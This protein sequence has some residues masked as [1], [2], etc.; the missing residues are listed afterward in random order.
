MDTVA[1]KDIVGYE[2]IYQ[3]S[4]TGQVK[5]L[6]AAK[7]RSVQGNYILAQVDNGSGHIRVGLC[8][9]SRVTR[10][11]VHR[12]VA[13]AFLSPPSKDQTEINHKNGNP[14][15]NRVENLEWV[16]R[17]ENERHAITKL[18]K[19]NAGAAN[20]MSKLTTAQVLEIRALAK[21]GH[22]RQS[23]AQRFNV[24]YF[25]IRNIAMRKSWTHI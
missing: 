20:G 16:T 11:Y 19:S 8:Y 9:H 3:V 24:S 2:D 10:Y 5:R 12:L 23:L 13:T 22:G 4:S 21:S 6:A 15:D 18:G 7:G 14:S 25:T 17:L 1:W